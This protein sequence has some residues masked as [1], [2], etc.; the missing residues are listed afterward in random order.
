MILK[1]ASDSA[2]PIP[3]L[4]ELRQQNNNTGEFFALGPT[5]LSKREW[6]AGMAMQ[7]L[8]SDPNLG[9]NIDRDPEVSHLKLD[10]A[11]A[12]ISLAY[13]DALIKKL[14]EKNDK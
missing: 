5:G 6:F 3:D 4:I 8:L 13:A 1:N 9:Q 7:G 11:V 2:F 12:R 14:G 10:I